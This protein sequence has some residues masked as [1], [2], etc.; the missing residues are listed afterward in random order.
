MRSKHQGSE[1]ESSFVSLSP[2][3]LLFLEGHL[4]TSIDK[5]MKK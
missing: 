2:V 4:F 3:L 5:E 1:G